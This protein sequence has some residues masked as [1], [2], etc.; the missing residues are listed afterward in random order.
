ME[1]IICIIIML[2]WAM[3]FYFCGYVDGKENACKYIV[4]QAVF[5][6]TEEN[7]GEHNDV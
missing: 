6:D 7:E 5:K 4:E 1:Y 2:V 3:I